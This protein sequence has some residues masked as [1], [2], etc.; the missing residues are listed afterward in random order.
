MANLQKFHL[1]KLT[2]I[3]RRTG[4]AVHRQDAIN[5]YKIHSRTSLRVRTP[6]CRSV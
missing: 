2:Y 4:I 1:A 3:L 5:L 6:C